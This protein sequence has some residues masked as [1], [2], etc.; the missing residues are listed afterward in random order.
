MRSGSLKNKIDIQFYSDTKNSFG[1]IEKGFNLF[2]STYASIVPVSGKEY[3]TS[4]Q[5]N[6]EVTHKILFRYIA[7][8]TPSMRIVYGSR[9]FSIES[10]LNIRE[11][12]KTIQLMATE[13][14]ND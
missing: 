14:I 3:F 1:E 4:K 8:I 5:N 6:S 11:E 2:K 13:I 7:G 12:N 9:T 10:V